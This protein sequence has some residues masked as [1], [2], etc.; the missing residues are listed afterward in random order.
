[1]KQTLKIYDSSSIP[2]RSLA[3]LILILFMCTLLMNARISLPKQRIDI[4]QILEQDLDAAQLAFSP[5]S[6][7]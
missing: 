6:M 4:L 1:M 7:A 3:L 5:S 2:K